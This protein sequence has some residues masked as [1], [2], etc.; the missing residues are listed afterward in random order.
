MKVIVVPTDFTI[1]A[2]NAVLYA[3]EL[4]LAYK[5]KLMLIHVC[6]V[7]GVTPILWERSP[8]QLEIE[9]DARVGMDNLTKRIR[10]RFMGVVMVESYVG[11]GNPKSKIKDFVH[12]NHADLVVMGVRETNF[13][14]SNPN[15]DESSV[16]SIYRNV[17]CPVLAVKHKSNFRSIRKVL[18]AYDG[19]VELSRETSNML[20]TF[21]KRFNAQLKVITV[22]TGDE[23]EQIITAEAKAHLNKALAEI[24]FEFEAV[25]GKDVLGEIQ[26]KGKEWNADLLIMLPHQHNVVTGIFQHHQSEKMVFDSQI[27]VLTMYS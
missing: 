20:N 25:H 17:G 19:E 14:T 6:A 18:L 26:Q 1:T 16:K 21:S 23:N 24:T 2:A 22:I 7:S 4:A 9:A 3:A 12:D 15:W 5:A 27:P 11:W 8:A 10:D 13:L